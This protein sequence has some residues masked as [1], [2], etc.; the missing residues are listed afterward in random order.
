MKKLIRTLAMLLCVAMLFSLVACGTN[1]VESTP[2][3]SNPQGT[4]K[5]SANEETL[6]LGGMKIT[7]GD[8]WSALIYEPDAPQS[9]WDQIVLDYRE[10]L[11]KKYNF[12]YEN[13]GIQNLGDYDTTIINSILGKKPVCSFFRAKPESV[14]SMVAQGL[15]WD[16]S[17]FDAFDF[18]N[19]PL[20][21]EL[22]TDYYTINGKVYAARPGVDEPRDGIFWNKRMFEEAGLD[23]DLPYD[24][25]ASGEW[26]WE[27][28][29]EIC[30]KLVKDYDN[31]GV[32][33]VYAL[34]APD[35]KL[36]DMG[37]YGNGA[38]FVEKDENGKYVDGTLNPAFQEGM[39][40]IVSLIDNGYID[41]PTSETGSGDATWH[42][43]ADGKAA[44]TIAQT[45]CISGYFA[46]MEDDYG[47][48]M[49]PA[50]PN[51]TMC[52][53]MYP[54]PIAIPSCIDWET[55]NQIAYI[56]NEWYH[57]MYLPEYEEMGI[58]ELD[59]YYYMF[60]DSRAVDETIKRMIT[61]GE[62]Q[63]YDFYYLIPNYD[64]Y[65]YVGTVC[66]REQT[67]ASKIEEKRPSAQ[68]AI[69]LA[70]AMLGNG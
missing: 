52:S 37:I 30:A 32:T 13:I 70:N 2:G 26:T 53:N 34:A 35:H 8:W 25:Q 57:L 3:E 66:W 60:R 41:P 64:Y 21:S 68:A 50:G 4:T 61:P 1:P 51:G 27:K 19:D 24:L 44:M 14:T 63:V 39:E 43:F 46:D 33:D 62:N 23:P 29:E 28:F 5:P 9:A 22:I 42:S 12:T 11:Q 69:D 7:E 67:P 40:W 17:S 16:L 38:M 48:V 54:T 58:T 59:G 36:I 47:Y 20:W 49:L 6:D 18:E 31:D 45:W 15:L 10:E 55:A 56:I 65:G